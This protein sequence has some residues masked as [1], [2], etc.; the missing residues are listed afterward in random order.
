VHERHMVTVQKSTL[1]QPIT[2]RN[3]RFLGQRE[4]DNILTGNVE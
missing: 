3:I 4:K 1:V 2:I